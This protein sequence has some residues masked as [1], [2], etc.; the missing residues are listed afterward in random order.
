M[1]KD[2]DTG[3]L[4]PSGEG[5]K[6]NARLAKREF[7]HRLHAG[8]DEKAGDHV[9]CQRHDQQMFAVHSAK[10]F[11]RALGQVNTVTLV[12]GVEKTGSA[13]GSRAGLGGAPRPLFLIIKKSKHYG[14]P[15]K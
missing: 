5:T 13:R 11:A 10:K 2:E 3:S 9:Q 14:E 6:R 8:E 4:S 1:L 7:L 15:P 12:F